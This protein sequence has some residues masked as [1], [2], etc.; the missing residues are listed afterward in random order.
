M[1]Y[2]DLMDGYESISRDFP[3]PQYSVSI[4]HG[5]MK[6]AEKDSEMKRFSEGKTDIMVATT[7]IEVGVNVPNASVMIIESAER[8]GLSQLH[9]LRGRVGRG[10]EQS[11]CILMT[12]HKLSND[13]K[14]RM[15]TMVRTNDGF[16]IAE[17]DLRLRGPGDI[18][19][20]Q[21]S[22]VLNLKIADLVL[23][24]DILQLARHHAKILLKDDPSMS[25][26]E[27]NLLRQAYIELT[28]KKNIWN[29]IS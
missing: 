28:R 9:Q 15:E 17:V 11:Y 18:M 1:D 26:P 29:H 4:L 22:G 12:G 3:L 25:K 2:K 21:Q 27:H 16:E 5:K 23:D 13:S 7:V 10:A 8:F 20:T 14:I 6:P 19:G 24:R